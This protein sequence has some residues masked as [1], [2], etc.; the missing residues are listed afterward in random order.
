MSCFLMEQ[1]S[2]PISSLSLS[3]PLFLGC[4]LFLIHFRISS[5]K[6]LKKPIDILMKI[7]L[8]TKLNYRIMNMF[9][10]VSC[11]IHVYVFS[12]NIFVSSLSFINKV[13]Y[14]CSHPFFHL[15]PLGKPL[16][17]IIFGSVSVLFCFF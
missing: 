17:L 8:N 13:L 12:L 9:T 10:I 14:F 6:S 1:V 4:F 15:S 7:L 11:P 16:V 5:S 3:W 2:Q